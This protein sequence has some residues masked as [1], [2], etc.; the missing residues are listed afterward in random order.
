[1]DELKF[2]TMEQSQCGED[3]RPSNFCGFRIP[4]SQQ[5]QHCAVFESTKTYHRGP[6]LPNPLIH[7]A[8]CDVLSIAIPVIDDSRAACVASTLSLYLLKQGNTVQ[9]LGPVQFQQR[10]VLERWWSQNRINHQVTT[11][12]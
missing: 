3:H 7:A 2:G 9:V 12:S 10:L 6:S 1:M 11:G 4:D 5:H 8:A